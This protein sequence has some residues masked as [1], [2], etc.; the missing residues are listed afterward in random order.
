MVLGA[1]L[2][3][4]PALAARVQNGCFSGIDVLYVGLQK[5][6]DYQKAFLQ[7]KGVPFREQD[8]TFV[9]GKEIAAFC[10]RYSHVLVHFDIDVLDPAF[11]HATY[12]A[13]PALT[14]D[15][16]GGGCMRMEKLTEI[17]ELIQARSDIA[18]FTIAEFLPFEEQRLRQMLAKVHIFTT[19]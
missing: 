14:G 2:G 4:N 12:F 5:I 7:Q 15:G 10:S 18:G 1:L 16:S 3:G 11:F 19:D 13:S 17:L 6:F 9:S 8:Q